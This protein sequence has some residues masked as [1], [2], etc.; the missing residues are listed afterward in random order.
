MTIENCGSI[1]QVNHCLPIATFNL[2]DENDM[3]KCFNWINLRLMYSN[4]KN[5]KNAKIGM[6]LFLL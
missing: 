4:E 2:L 3:K 1:W 6:R 5:S